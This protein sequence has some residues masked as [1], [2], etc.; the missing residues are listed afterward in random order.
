MI[1]YLLLNTV[2]N[3]GYIGQHKGDMIST[4]WNTYLGGA[5]THL[6]GA[7][8]KYGLSAFSREILSHCSSREEMNN[9]EKLWILALK[10]YDPKCGYNKTFGGEGGSSITW[11]LEKRIKLG[12]IV[13]KIC[14]EKREKGIKRFSHPPSTSCRKKQS[15][16]VSNLVWIT[17][18]IVN[19]RINKGLEVPELWKRGKV[20]RNPLSMKEIEAYTKNIAKAR[21]KRLHQFTAV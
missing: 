6:R 2:N 17:N 21:Q 16:R 13:S 9:L 19:K 11:T 15:T 1:V 20:R 10:T 4:R 7:L 5:N 14:R 3:K 18:G 12:K 8:N